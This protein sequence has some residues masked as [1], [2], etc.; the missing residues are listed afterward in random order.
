MQDSDQFDAVW[1]PGYFGVNFAWSVTGSN[2]T[3]PPTTGGT[4]SAQSQV[5]PTKLRL[6]A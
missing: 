4:P 2:L 3:P 1:S 6:V 5:Q